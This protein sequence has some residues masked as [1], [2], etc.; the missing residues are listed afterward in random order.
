MPEL[1]WTRDPSLRPR[2]APF[3]W[4]RD[5]QHAHAVCVDQIT[6]E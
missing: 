3:A 1:S 4:P 5:F 2:R 6:H